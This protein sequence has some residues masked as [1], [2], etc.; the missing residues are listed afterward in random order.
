MAH[1]NIVLIVCD[2]L[3]GDCLGA[4]GHPDVKTPY[5]DTLAAEGTLFEHAYSA[6]PSCIP[7]PRRPAHRPGSLVARARGL[8]G[9]RGLDL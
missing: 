2:Q 7:A 9:R 8:S 3:R 6:C 1:P 5:L 4:A